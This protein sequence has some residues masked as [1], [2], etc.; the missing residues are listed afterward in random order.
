MFLQASVIL[1]TGGD[2]YLSAC[3]DASPPGTRDPPDQADPQPPGTRDPPGPETPPDQAD[4]PD[5]RP[6]RTRQTP[7]DETPREADASIRSMRGRYASYW[8]A[9]LFDNTMKFS[10]LKGRSFQHLDC[11]KDFILVRNCSA[12]LE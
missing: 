4:P 11:T 1:S 9:F 6:P 3:W 5:Q 8:N 10:C 12:R 7:R 2:V